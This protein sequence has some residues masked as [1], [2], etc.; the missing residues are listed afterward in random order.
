[1]ESSKAVRKLA[2]PEARAWFSDGSVMVQH[3]FGEATTTGRE[4]VSCVMLCTRVVGCV[5]RDG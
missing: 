3:R 5:E 4:G 2:I 1:M